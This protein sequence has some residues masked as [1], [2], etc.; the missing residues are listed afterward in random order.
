[1]KECHECGSKIGMLSGYKHP[2]FGKKHLICWDCH[3]KID[4]SVAEWR[5]FIIDHKDLENPVVEAIPDYVASYFPN[6]KKVKVIA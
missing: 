5:Q 1:M 3:E 4:A 6:V 2:T